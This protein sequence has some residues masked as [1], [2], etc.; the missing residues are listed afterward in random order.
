MKQ[1][2]SKILFIL[3]FLFVNHIKCSTIGSDSSVDK[4]ST[5][6]TLNDG[7]RVACFAGLNAGFKINSADATATF[8]SIFAVSGNIEIGLGTLTLTQDLILFGES[9]IKS[10]GN[11]NG[12]SHT[13]ELAH[14][15]T[16]F[17]SNIK[18]TQGGISVTLLSSKCFSDDVYSVDWSY[19]S[20][21]IAVVIDKDKKDD[22]LFIYSFNGSNLTFKKDAYI[23]G[24]DMDV[25]TVRWN[26][27]NY[28]L[29]IATSYTK[30]YTYEYSSGSNSLSQKD[31]LSHKIY[32]FDWHTGGN[33]IATGR[34]TSYDE[35]ATYYIYNDGSINSSPIDEVNLSPS[36]NPREESISFRN[37]GN[38]F[39]VG[40]KTSDGDEVL[41]YSFSSGNI[42]LNAS[43]GY[44]AHVNAVSWNPN[45]PD[46]IVVGLNGTS[47]T[48]RILK[49]NSGA[50][51][52][53]EVADFNTSVITHA[54]DWSPNG[55]YFAAGKAYSAIAGDNEFE[56]YSFNSGSETISK[57]TGFD[58]ANRVDSVRFSPNGKYIA[59]GTFTNVLA[60]YSFESTQGS[61][62]RNFTFDN[63]HIILG[64]DT[65]IQNY[66]I[67]FSGQS[68]IIG[69]GH[70]LSLAPTGTIIVDS[71]S[72]LLLKD[73]VIT[74]I[75]EN[76]I[77]LT[78]NTSTVT[79]QNVA[80]ILDDDFYVNY[81]KLDIKDNFEIYGQGNTFS[82][83]SS[84]QSTI[85]ENS[86]LIL[87]DDTTLYYNPTEASNNLIML[88]AS[89]SQLVLNGAT[90]QTTSTGLQLTKGI[91]LINNNSS[92]ENGGTVDGEAIELGD[93]VNAENNIS[94]QYKPA[95]CLNLT[96]G[97]VINKN[98]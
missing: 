82:Y 41:V 33:Y 32:A 83:Q 84:E 20:Q 39:V 80:W 78:D 10:I 87:Q 38:Y 86:K 96:S 42:S 63:I 85:Y 61:S 51:T 76:N 62:G 88:N 45:Y 73:V 28:Y 52:L 15:N 90:L 89:T 29:A 91:L 25:Y 67:T 17:P 37:D 66:E 48:I 8:D 57:S 19:D 9:E 75:K 3:F 34:S 68:S 47:Q 97:I 65:T 23:D 64:A 71:D 93:G 69:H 22:G 6:Q 5:Q 53:T 77:S 60:V 95:A 74:G 31:N 4:F 92:L 79:L 72:S 94:I 7:D 27:N 35:I 54:L 40:T 14:T 12:N 56:I 46:Y 58:Y 36:R 26:P 21:Y 18:T 55:D 13:L 30:F 16:T 44:S 2:I 59:I 11:I 24:K 98:V 70:V 1:K 43:Y 50:G 49:H 81:G